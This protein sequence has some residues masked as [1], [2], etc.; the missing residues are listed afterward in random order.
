MLKLMG[1]NRIFCP[2]LKF[3]GYEQGF[4]EEQY[5][6]LCEYM[7]EIGYKLK[8]KLIIRNVGISSQKYF[9]KKDLLRMQYINYIDKEVYWKFRY[10]CRV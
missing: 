5:V 8:E 4:T 9:M 7:M 10:K 3:D 2:I 6:E 1:I